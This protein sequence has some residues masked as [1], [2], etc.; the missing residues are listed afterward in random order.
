M[1][2]GISKAGLIAAFISLTGCT[3]AQQSIF[4]SFDLDDGR[5]LATGASQRVII[6]TNTHPSSR[7]GR[8]NPERIVCAEP[9]PDV[10]SIVAN[11]F[12]F[13]VNVLGKGN[14]AVSGGQAT[15]LAQLAER[16]VTVQLLRDQ[17]YRACE[18]YA[19]GAISGTEYS[20]LM[21]RNN[22]AMVTLMLGESASRL[23]GRQLAN[24]TAAAGSDS[25]ASMP[26]LLE[27]LNNV[28]ETSEQE[29][30]AQDELTEATDDAGEAD[31]A[32]AATDSD[33]S[34]TAT[35]E[36]QEENEETEDALS[37][38]QDNVDDAKEEAE[39]AR[40]TAKNI[41][42]ATATPG[43]GGGFQ[44]LNEHAVGVAEQL[45]EMQE[46]FLAQGAQEHFISAC[47]VELGKTSKLYADFNHYGDWVW[48]EENY[49][50][51]WVVPEYNPYSDLTFVKKDYNTIQYTLMN[52]I[53]KRY[54]LNGEPTN[55]Y[56]AHRRL[57]EFELRALNWAYRNQK[58]PDVI[59]V[60]LPIDEPFTAEH[61]KNIA[62]TV[63]L[64]MQKVVTDYRVLAE[65]QDGGTVETLGEELRKAFRDESEGLSDLFI[66]ETDKTDRLLRATMA[67]EDRERASFLAKACLA[68]FS[69]DNFWERED[70]AR[71]Y[72][73]FFD[74]VE[75]VETVRKGASMPR[76]RPNNSGANTPAP[77]ADIAQMYIDYIK[78]D[79]E[80][81]PKAPADVEICR[82]RAIGKYYGGATSQ[83]GGGERG[84]V[85]PKSGTHVVQLASRQYSTDEAKK[86][87]KAAL[88]KEWE[89]I[90][91][92]NVERLKNKKEAIEESEQA[93]K[94]FLSL[95]VG[96]YKS[97]AAAK[98][99]CTDSKRPDDKCKVIKLKK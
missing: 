23:V 70:E 47:V 76:A 7:P 19:N 87:V 73:D 25:E 96:P 74:F 83:R 57:T 98:K 11:T 78:C 31:A 41:L 48:N 66:D 42:T 14:A 45:T 93:G 84:A 50:W 60:G 35:E 43:G 99:F 90:K 39:E 94:K 5:S 82:V 91:E 8:V 15:A 75:D 36:V 4:R 68:Q 2:M 27:A 81:D 86:T 10:A 71:R 30:E 28:V 20:L 29:S 24:L 95:I 89:S 64:F 55:N 58:H 44:T 80:T 21:S 92:K 59:A 52:A 17:M 46:Q 63:T 79:N 65:L 37:D 3:T 34:E 69:D 12:G 40:A 56:K 61:D 18:A 88:E 62:A 9:S 32:A 49:D 85:D 77:K 33:D 16:T 22:D 72:R 97:N 6:N 54:N 51:E 1:G 26:A 53:D 67:I 38:A 13:G